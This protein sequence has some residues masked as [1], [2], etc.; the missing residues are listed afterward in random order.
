VAGIS[1]ICSSSSIIWSLALSR[2]RPAVS[3]RRGSYCSR[4]LCHSSRATIISPARAREFEKPFCDETTHCKLDRC[5]VEHVTR[6]AFPYPGRRLPIRCRS[7]RGVRVQPPQQ[8]IDWRERAA[9]H[10]G[11]AGWG[12]S[13]LRRERTPIGCPAYSSP[14]STSTDMLHLIC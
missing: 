1:A 14:D 8:H 9:L 12:F 7:C 6:P 2:L 11:G 3:K 10:P 5:R 4:V 13:G